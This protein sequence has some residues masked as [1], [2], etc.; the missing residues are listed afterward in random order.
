M[1]QEGPIYRVKY[2][3]EVLVEVFIQGENEEQA[4]EDAIES[5]N[6]V[7]IAKQARTSYGIQSIQRNSSLLCMVDPITRLHGVE[8]VEG[9]E[10]D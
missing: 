4:A 6:L 5:C 7:Q 9:V 8:R 2:S 1:E 10:L 3:V